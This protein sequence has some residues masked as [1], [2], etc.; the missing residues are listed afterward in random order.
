MSVKQVDRQR[1]GESPRKPHCAL[2]DAAQS[3]YAA[4]RGVVLLHLKER[5]GAWKRTNMISI[6][7][8]CR[9]VC[10]GVLGQQVLERIATR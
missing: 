1:R 10:G 2:Y 5:G 3:A 4:G 7:M 9:A 8:D 6:G